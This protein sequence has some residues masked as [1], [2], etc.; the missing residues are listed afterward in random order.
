MIT[1]LITTNEDFQALKISWN[2]LHNIANG[3]IFQSFTWNY[4]W[5]QNHTLR[6][7]NFFRYIQKYSYFYSRRV[8]SFIE[9][10]WD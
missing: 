3:T 4:E 2:D 1:K 10:I 9:N 5:W 7:Y 8:R 6:M